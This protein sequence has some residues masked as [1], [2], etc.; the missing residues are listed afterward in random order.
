MIRD[1]SILLAA[2][3]FILLGSYL[4][5]PYFVKTMFGCFS[6]MLKQVFWMV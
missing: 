2:S 5:D 4:A 1:I 3:S 6:E